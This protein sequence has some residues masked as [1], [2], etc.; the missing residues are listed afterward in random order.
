[1]AINSYFFK[2]VICFESFQFFKGFN[3]APIVS[4]TSIKI[5]S[6]TKKINGFQVLVEIENLY[7]I[8]ILC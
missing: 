2:Y 3:T 8:I 5:N 7:K 4:E 6:I 1:M